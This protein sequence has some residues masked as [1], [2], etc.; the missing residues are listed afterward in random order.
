[1]ARNDCQFTT[2]KIAEEINMNKETLEILTD[3][4]QRSG[5]EETLP[6]LFQKHLSGHQKLAR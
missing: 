5:H 3:F 6:E 1:M 2:C 4:N